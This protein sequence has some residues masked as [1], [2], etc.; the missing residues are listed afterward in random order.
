LLQHGLDLVYSRQLE[1][2]ST[3]PIP[4][5]GQRTYR[6]ARNG[7]P[8]ASVAQYDENENGRTVDTS[9]L[10]VDADAGALGADK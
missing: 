3:D 6:T 8:R 9:L 10:D 1:I 7:R 4:I 5:G 2:G